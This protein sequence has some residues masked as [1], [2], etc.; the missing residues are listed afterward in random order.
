MNDNLY[1]VFYHDGRSPKQIRSRDI[2]AD[3]LRFYG[4]NK[5]ITRELFYVRGHVAKN[6]QWDAKQKRWRL[7][8]KIRQ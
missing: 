3:L 7:K 8:N 2:H 5:A 4:S 1:T 6:Y